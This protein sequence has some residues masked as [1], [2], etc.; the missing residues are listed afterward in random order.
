MVAGDVRD[1]VAE[2]A[3]S[4]SQSAPKADIIVSELLGSFGD[5][6]LSPECLDSAQALLRPSGISIP[7]DYSSQL[8][9]I[10]SDT[11]WN[12]VKAF[13]ATLYG[14]GEIP[15]QLVPFETAFVVKMHAGLPL[16]ASQPCFTFVHPNPLVG[17]PQH[18]NERVATMTF[19]VPCSVQAT[20]H[21]F[22]GTF[23]STLYGKETLSIH[24][25]TFSEGM[26]SWFP[27]FFPLRDPMELGTRQISC[28]SCR[29]SEVSV[30]STASDSDSRSMQSPCCGGT[31]ITLHMWR[32]VSPSSN[33]VWYEWAVTDPRVSHI[34]NAGGRAQWIGL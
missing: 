22:V 23:E 1:L 18:S 2:Q 16:C 19:R 15:P 11:L 29:P 12:N 17:T 26:F 4:E 6:E 9:P 5:N 28:S 27:L 25:P 7:C 14:T 34:H 21:G 20:L 32:V 31:T 8:V 33:R 30:S 13:A 24:P 10:A 3:R